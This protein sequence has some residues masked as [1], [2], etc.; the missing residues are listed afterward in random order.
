MSVR[1][2]RKGSK[3]EKTSTR[4]LSSSSISTLPIFQYASYCLPTECL[5]TTM[6]GLQSM[7]LAPVCSFVVVGLSLRI[8]TLPFHVYAEKILSKRIQTS[9]LL[10]RSVIEKI[11]NHYNVPVV[12]DPES[13]RM[14][15]D[16][17]EVKIHRHAMELTREKTMEF[18]I[19][20]R[21]Q[22]ARVFC[23]KVC[24]APL[25]I[26]SSFSIRNILI[27][28]M[29]HLGGF[30]WLGD[31]AQPDPYTA[32]PIACGVV[33]F[34]NIYAHRFGPVRY[35]RF[36]EAM[37]I[38]SVI[39]GIKIMSMIP[40]CISIYWLSVLSTSLLQSLLLRHPKVKQW[41]GIGPLPTD[42]PT[43]FRDLF[44]LKRGDLTR[45]LK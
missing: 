16:T 10:E 45:D 37:Q 38:V 14:R 13:G 44:Y 27:E 24:T 43:P 18:V 42:S 36:Y 31:L 32:L 15:L 20:H 40:A 28:D 8:L 7:G 26:L 17:G 30:L 22:L 3:I 35:K 34:L 1:G 21:L 4:Q 5:Q 41:L 39:V 23:L 11:G 2:P 25:W 9:H 12:M 6:L 19:K 29:P 33:A